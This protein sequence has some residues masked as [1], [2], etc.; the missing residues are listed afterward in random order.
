M[1]HEDHPVQEDGCRPTPEVCSGP[2][3]GDCIVRR[4]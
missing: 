3:H 2:Q 1:E 4:V